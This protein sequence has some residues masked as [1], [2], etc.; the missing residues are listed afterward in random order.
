MRGYVENS[1]PPQPQVPQCKI[2][3]TRP[4]VIELHTAFQNLFMIWHFSGQLVDGDQAGAILRRARQT[5]QANCPPS[6]FSRKGQAI[7][8][9]MPTILKISKIPA[10]YTM[11][12]QRMCQKIDFMKWRVAI[13]MIC[14]IK[15]SFVRIRS[16]HSLVVVGQ[17]TPGAIAV[18]QL[19]NQITIK[20]IKVFQRNF[21]TFFKRGV[22]VWYFKSCLISSNLL[23]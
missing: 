23:N 9:K 2:S 21:K 7:L 15:H 11:L 5:V 14:Q 16:L 20:I 1:I 22:G 19:S 12:S 3:E 10:L 17:Q 4:I 18:I 13:E 6:N 8:I